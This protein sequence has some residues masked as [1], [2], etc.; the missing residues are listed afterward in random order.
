M[1]LRKLLKRL[2]AA[3]ESGSVAIAPIAAL[4]GSI[5]EVEPQGRGPARI[6]A[7]IGPAAWLPRT[8]A[9]PLRPGTALGLTVPAARLRAP[10][11]STVLTKHEALSLLISRLR[12][13]IVER[14]TLGLR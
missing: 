14:L 4:T 12:A 2:Q 1:S 7:L 11:R 10:D 8:I 3:P 13:L 6:P 5:G 9:I